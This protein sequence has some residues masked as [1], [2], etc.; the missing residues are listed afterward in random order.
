MNWALG[1][2][3]RQEQRDTVSNGRPG[4][5]DGGGDVR[6]A[7]WAAATASVAGE[8]LERN[9]EVRLFMMVNEG[10]D[11]GLCRERWVRDLV[12]EVGMEAESIRGVVTGDWQRIGMVRAVSCLIVCRLGFGV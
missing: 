11:D 1:S 3:S 7:T 9:G 6:A 8:E 5:H 4:L 12:F 10:S 2:P